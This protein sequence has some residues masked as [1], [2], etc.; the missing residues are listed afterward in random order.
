M[1]HVKSI[2]LIFAVVLFSVTAAAAADREYLVLLP[3][4][5]NGAEQGEACRRGFEMA[6]EDLQAGGITVHLR[7][8]DTAGVPAA[9][10]SAYRLARSQKNIPV[11]FSWGSTVGMALSPIVN[12]DHVIQMGVATATPKYRTDNDYNFRLSPAA[13]SEADFLIHAI[14]ERFQPNSIAALYIE[15]DYG[16]GSYAAALSTMRLLGKEFATTKS[17][18]PDT[19]DFR[20]ILTQ[21]AASKPDFVYLAAYPN[22]GALILKQARELGIQSKFFSSVAI[23]GALGFF[24]MAN[25]AA[26]GLLLTTHEYVENH[27]LFRRYR[28]R[29][30]EVPITLVMYA[31]RAFEALMIVNT[32][33]NK[34]AN[35]DAECIR[36]ELM[37]TNTNGSLGRLAFDIAGDTKFR[38][39]LYQV[40][41]SQLL[42]AT[43]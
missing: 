35:I 8:E 14:V 28:E 4:H 43:Q 19:T 11:V 7:Y 32:A 16:V 6:R 5:G 30:G 40:H 18:L 26:E 36:Q 1:D 23:A 24:D 37:A 38:Y 22:D 20:A 31:A 17:Y 9:A 41:G 29:F 13:D 27:P 42:K 25:G 34:C 33:A 12:A 21:I 3:L 39:D 10:I 15:N 2:F